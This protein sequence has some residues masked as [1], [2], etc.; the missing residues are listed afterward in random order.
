MNKEDIIHEHSEEKLSVYQEYLDSYLSVLTNQKYFTTINVIDLFAGLGISKNQKKGSAMVAVEVIHEHRKKC[1]VNFYLNEKDA[2]KYKILKENLS[3]YD[4]PVITNKSAD[5]FVKQLFEDGCLSPSN[6]KNSRSLL[7][8]DP[9]GYTQLSIDNLTKILQQSEIE[10]LIFVPVYSI[11]RFRKAEGNPAHRFLLDLGIEESAL[12][13]IQNMDSFVNRLSHNFKEKA[14][15][16]FGY[17]YELKN[18]NV[19]NSSFHMFFITRNITGAEK[20]LEAKS[21]IKTKLKNQLTLFDV[22]YPQKKDDLINMLLQEKTNKE[23]HAAIIKKGYLPRE[24]K[25]ILKEMER[26]GKLKVRADFDKRKGYYYL[27]QK[28]DRTIYLKYQS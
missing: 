4:F 9:Y 2:E 1:D 17:S 23:L 14:N 25:P 20:F 8:I 22:E 13:G 10:V 21:K 18:K 12:S 7:F 6:K 27:N 26:N 15:T 3:R 28:A 16:E 24:I 19:A 5:D 11:Y